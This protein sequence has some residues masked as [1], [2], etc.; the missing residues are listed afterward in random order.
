VPGARVARSVQQFKRELAETA[1]APARLPLWLA[2]RGAM[3]AEG[4]ALESGHWL[5]HVYESAAEA[6][7]SGGRYPMDAELWLE[8]GGEELARMRS[9]VS[10]ELQASRAPAAA[11]G[12]YRDV[13]ACMAELYSRGVTLDWEAFDRPFSRMKLSLPSYPLERKRCWLDPP[14]VTLPSTSVQPARAP[15]AHP[16]LQRM[17]MRAP[18]PISVGPAV[19]SGPTLEPRQGTG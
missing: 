8:L 11:G 6:A 14:I 3:L 19:V 13:L 12:D 2:S 7:A 5:Q 10:S 17:T 15:S 4:G 9:G 1:F 18:A 16:L